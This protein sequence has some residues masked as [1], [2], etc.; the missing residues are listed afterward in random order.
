M[1]TVGGAV[2]RRGALGA[3]HEA[4]QRRD[5]PEADPGDVDDE[6]HEHRLL[7]A[8]QPADREHQPHLMHEQRG[9]QARGRDQE[10]AGEP[11]AGLGRA[12]GARPAAVAARSGSA[13]PS[14][15]APVGGSGARR[16]G[17]QPRRKGERHWLHRYTQVSA[18]GRSPE[19]RSMRSSTWSL[20]SGSSSKL[21][22]S[23]PTSGFSEMCASC[24]DPGFDLRRELDRGGLDDGLAVAGEVDDEAAAVVAAVADQR[25]RDAQ[26][27]ARIGRVPAPVQA[28][29]QRN[30]AAGG[31]RTGRPPVG[32]DVVVH[33]LGGRD[34]DEDDV[35]APPVADR[36]DPD[37]RA[38]GGS[39]R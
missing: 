14:R 1:R 28:V 37:R 17:R 26:Q 8:G 2:G 12:A 4:H 3:E 5:R 25:A 7:D 29:G 38:G 35:P 15:A 36:L 16:T 10:A 9:Q 13:R 20:P 32:D 30:L 34:L 24:S 6:E 27:P 18:I 39:G 21:R 22:R 33:L 31:G 23:P 11:H 19:R